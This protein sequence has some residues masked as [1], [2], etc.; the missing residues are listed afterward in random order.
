MAAHTFTH[1][2][3]GGTHFCVNLKTGWCWHMTAHTFARVKKFAALIIAAIAVISSCDGSAIRPW[4]FFF[5]SPWMTINRS[6]FISCTCAMISHDGSDFLW[7]MAECHTPVTVP[8]HAIALLISPLT[9]YILYISSRIF[10]VC[11]TAPHSRRIAFAVIA[12][13][14]PL[15]LWWRRLSTW[16][17]YQHA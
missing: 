13:I 5:W 10:R 14:P 12:D 11:G 9:L 15:C 1:I 4:R 3:N 2:T 17:G 16:W 7:G 8:S 6:S